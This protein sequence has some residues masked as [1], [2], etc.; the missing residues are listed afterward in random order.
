MSRALQAAEKL[1]KDGI[2]A[3]VVEIHTLKPLDHE[4]IRECASTTGNLIT[5]EE[6]SMVGGLG[7]AVAESIS[8]MAGTRLRIIGLQD[9]F[10]ET[11]PYEDLLNKYGFSIDH[12]AETTKE[13]LFNK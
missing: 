2:S 10:A 13:F 1:Q 5:I 7:S 9:R 6:H 12:L 4:L 8:E 11:G 3:E